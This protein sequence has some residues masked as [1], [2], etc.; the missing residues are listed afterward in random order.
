MKHAPIV[1]AMPF[2]PLEHATIRALSLLSGF[3]LPQ[4]ASALVMPKIPNYSM[5]LS[6]SIV[7]NK[8]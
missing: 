7:A 5:K 4:V 3:L 8:K 1:L 2:A 6:D